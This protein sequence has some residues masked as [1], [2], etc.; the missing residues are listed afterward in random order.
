M[1]GDM[2]EASVRRIVRVQFLGGN[3]TDTPARAG[4][5]ATFAAW[6]QRGRVLVCIA[7]GIIWAIDAWFKWQ[8]DF[9]HRCLNI[10]QAGAGSQ[11]GWVAPWYHSWDVALQPFAPFVAICAAMIETFIAAAL[12]LGFARNS[13]YL[14]GALCSF[15]IRAIPEGFGNTSRSTYPD[16]ATSII[17]VTVFAALLALDAYSDPQRASL[18]ALIDRR[19][20]RWKRI[21]ELRNSRR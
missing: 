10:V 1:R 19:F 14:V 18:D 15:S 16:I 12:I 13:I 2:N 9:Q 5:D 11:P 7:F 3:A 20:P 4:P 8:P 17:Y 6:Q 21:A